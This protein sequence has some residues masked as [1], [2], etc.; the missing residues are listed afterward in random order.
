MPNI[1]P[2]NAVRYK[3]KDNIQ[4]K[5]YSPSKHQF[6]Q[7][8]CVLFHILLIN[9]SGRKHPQPCGPEV[10]IISLSASKCHHIL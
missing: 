7:R 3:L 10:E 8:V 4:V 9:V 5:E 6:Q 1:Q 2:S